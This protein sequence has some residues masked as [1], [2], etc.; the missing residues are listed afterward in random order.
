[1]SR[2]VKGVRE[3]KPSERAVEVRWVGR[4]AEIG[5]DR[6]HVG[7][8]RSASSELGQNLSIPVHRI[9]A[10]RRAEQLCQCESERSFPAPQI[11]PVPGRFGNRSLQE[12][13]RAPN[14]HFDPR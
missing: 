3:E 8:S 4:L 7:V 11:R 9:D 13:E 10:P 5:E 6:Y 1:M 2:E 14:I 12:G